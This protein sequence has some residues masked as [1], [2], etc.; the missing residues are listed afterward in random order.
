LELEVGQAEQVAVPAEL[1]LQRVMV[2]WVDHEPLEL[3]SPVV[4]PLQSK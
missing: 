3:P 2:L 4:L 1:V